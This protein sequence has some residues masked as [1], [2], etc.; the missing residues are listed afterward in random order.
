MALRQWLL[1][2]ILSMAWG[3]PE[4]AG[5]A[6]HYDYGEVTRDGSPFRL[7]APTCAVDASEWERLRGRMVYVLADNGR[8]AVLR[9][10]DTGRLYDAGRFEWAVIV[11]G[12]LEVARWWPSADG[13][14]VVLDV[15]RE[16]FRKLSPD[17][18]TVRV[19]VWV[20]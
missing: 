7:D 12:E 9:V 2:A 15:P 20:R 6:T 4:L 16:T 5:L 17:L 19:R 11:F 3:Q 18:E 8:L 13:D 1:V 10:T 14:R